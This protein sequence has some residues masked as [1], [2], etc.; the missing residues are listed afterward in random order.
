MEGLSPETPHCLLQ[1][2]RVA[3]AE[4]R[5][6]NDPVLERL[7]DELARLQAEANRE[8]GERSRW[9]RRRVA[10]VGDHRGGRAAS[11]WQPRAIPCAARVAASAH[12][13]RW[14]RDGGATLA[15]W[16][17]RVGRQDGRRPAPH[18]KIFAHDERLGLP[19]RSP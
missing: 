13:K 7:I 2:Y 3:L 18:R 19:N 8:A 15:R 11:E 4:L 17:D 16:G 10:K 12:E 9:R 1:T 14:A 5:E 6:K